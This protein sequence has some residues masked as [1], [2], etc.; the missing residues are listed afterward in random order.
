MST[1]GSLLPLKHL[2]NSMSA[3]LDPAGVT[4]SWVGIAVMVGWL[5]V[6][7]MLALRRSST[8]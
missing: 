8:S 1:V 4:V 3:A 2:A 6:A 5:V 7:G